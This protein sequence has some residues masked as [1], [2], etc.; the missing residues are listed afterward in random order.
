MAAKPILIVGSKN[1]SSWSL[2]PW[3]L[4]RQFGVEFDEV[5]LPLDT[6]EFHRRVRD[7]SPSGRVP[8][9]VVDDLHIWDSLAIVEY[10]NEQF[11]HNAG[12]PKDA[13]ARA[14]RPFDQRR[15]A[16][17]LLGAAQC[18]ADELSQARTRFQDRR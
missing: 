9:L 12:W 16:L 3:L 8:A 2:R 15:D 1:Y 13:A 18:D 5:K 11:L 6:P 10:A 7:Y 17:R 14:I 4:L